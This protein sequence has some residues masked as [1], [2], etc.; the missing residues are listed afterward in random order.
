MDPH[1]TYGVREA[2]TEIARAPSSVSQELARLREA[3]LVNSRQL[4]V[5]P[6]LF[7]ALARRWRPESI[8]VASLPESGT[9]RPR[10]PMSAALRLGFADPEREPGWAL[11]DTLAAIAYGAPWNTSGA[12]PPEF[13]VPD[14]AAMR[15]AR[16]L[17][18][19][20]TSRENR[21]ATLRVSPVPLIT[22]RRV[23]W[24]TE[25]PLAHPLFVALDLAQDPDRGSEALAAWDPPRR[26][27]RVW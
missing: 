18:G 17:L 19:G 12:Y 20:T 11:S 24:D 2:A 9:E 7:R 13:Y 8:D 6:D 5:L 27:Q 23:G 15:R 26:W 14:R 16:Q 10:D 1:R 22:D 4:P 21:A 3:G 25:W